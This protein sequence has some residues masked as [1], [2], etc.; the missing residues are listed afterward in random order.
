MDRLWRAGKSRLVKQIRDAPTKDAILKLM[1]D[2]L[3]FVDDWMDFVSEKTSANFKLKSKKY[4]AMKKKQLLHTCSR[5]GY[6]R[7]VEE[8]RKGSSDSSSVTKFAL[9][10]KAHKRK[11]GQP[12]NSQVAETLESLAFVMVFDIQPNI[13]FAYI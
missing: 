8:M 1:P 4:K 9:W 10:T 13:V 2:N 11:D 3:Q 7:L 12:V 6:A 5:K